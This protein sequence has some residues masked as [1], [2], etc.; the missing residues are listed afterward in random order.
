VGYICYILR[1]IFLTA[2]FGLREGVAGWEKPSSR[3]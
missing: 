1:A 2:S 3:L